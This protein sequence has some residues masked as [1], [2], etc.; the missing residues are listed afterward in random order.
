MLRS[1]VVL[2][3]GEAKQPPRLGKVFR[4][5]FALD[6]HD[7]EIILRIGVALRCGEPKQPPCLSKVFRPAFAVV[8]HEAEIILRIGVALRCSEPEQ[9]PRLCKVYW[10]AVAV[11]VHDAERTLRIGVALRCSRLKLAQPDLETLARVAHVLDEGGEFPSRAGASDAQTLTD[12]TR[13]KF[14]QLGARRP[15][16]R[17]VRLD[18]HVSSLFGMK[19]SE[20]RALIVA[21]EVSVHGAP[22]REPRWQVVLGEEATVTVAGRAP[23]TGRPFAHRLLLVHKP[24]GVLCERRRGSAAWNAAHGRRTGEANSAAHGAAHPEAERRVTDHSNLGPT[25]MHVKSV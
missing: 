18:A 23:P 20:A 10:P 11:A 15:R 17:M 9:P 2:R 24:R 12:L 21:G 25:T 14:G 4:P 7:A 3:C 1:C 16:A 6:M 19:Q 13:Q 22:Q 5:T 8:V